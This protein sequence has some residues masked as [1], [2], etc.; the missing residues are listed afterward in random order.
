MNHTE[1]APFA[2]KWNPFGPEL[3]IEAL[4]PTA[5]TEH[6]CRRI[7]HSLVREGGFALLTGEPGSGKS[8]VLRLLADRLDR[9]PEVQVGVLAHPQSSVVDFYRELGELFEV[10]IKPHNRWGGFKGLRERWQSHIESTLVHPVLLIDEAQEMSPAVLSELR[11]LSTSRFDSRNLLSVVLAGD[12]RLT[13]KLRREE[14]IALG[15]RIRIRLLLEPVSRTELAACLRHLIAKAGNAK[16]CTPTLID[17]L[18]EHALGNRRVLLNTAA[19]LLAQA[20]E[21][22]IAQLDE[23]LFLEVFSEPRAAQTAAPRGAKR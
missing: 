12:G 22:D 1:L 21:R 15:T 6:F 20:A 16:L 19:E 17:T 5:P 10:P 11:L 2:L 8:A 14:L 4:L 3:P 7:E 18:A 9:L 13:D 23:K